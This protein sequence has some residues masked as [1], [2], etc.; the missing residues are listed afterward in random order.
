MHCNNAE[1]E[2]VMCGGKLVWMQVGRFRV[3]GC[4]CLCDT[5]QRRLQ[6][7]IRPPINLMYCQ[8]GRGK[9]TKLHIV[10]KHLTWWFIGTGGE[11]ISCLLQAKVLYQWSDNDGI[12]IVL[13]TVVQIVQYW[14]TEAKMLKST[15]GICLV[16]FVV[17]K[18][19]AFSRGSLSSC[20][21]CL[22]LLLCLFELLSHLININY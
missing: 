7:N 2:A 3:R 16:V 18:R 1:G 21:C 15:V 22:G 4:V 20:C 12:N 19:S 10:S 6:C 5:I 11:N 9:A 17:Y 8:Q 13:R 14:N